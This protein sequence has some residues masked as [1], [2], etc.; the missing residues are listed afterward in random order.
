MLLSSTP[1]VEN[2]EVCSMWLCGGSELASAPERPKPGA[3]QSVSLGLV[4]SLPR[5]H[6][7]RPLLSVTLGSLPKIND[8]CSWMEPSLRQLVVKV[9]QESGP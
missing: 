6:L 1:W 2:S 9:T 5:F 4:L 3:V 8:S 7:P